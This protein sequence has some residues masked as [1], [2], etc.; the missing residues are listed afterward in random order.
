MRGTP[1]PVK[2]YRAMYV[3]DRR[4]RIVLQMLAVVLADLGLPLPLIQLWCGYASPLVVEQ[5]I[6]MGRKRLET[7]CWFASADEFRR[8]R[9]ALQHGH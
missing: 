3:P 7:G 5:M 2:R 1:E 6:A 4:R 9:D 8:W